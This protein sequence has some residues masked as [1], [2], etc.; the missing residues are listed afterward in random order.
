[1]KGKGTFIVKVKDTENATWQGTV[2]WV[3]GRKELPFRST[4]ELIK[5]LDSAIDGNISIVTRP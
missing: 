2:E 1:M 4:L 3:D 5:L